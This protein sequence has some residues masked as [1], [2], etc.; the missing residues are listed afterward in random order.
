MLV[1][2]GQLPL[3]QL[4][5][6]KLVLRNISTNPNLLHLAALEEVRELPKKVM[7]ASTRI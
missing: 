4:V 1:V 3:D 5:V 2:V 6:F 7:A